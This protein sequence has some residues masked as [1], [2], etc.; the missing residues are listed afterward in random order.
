VV[1]GI[2]SREIEKRPPNDAHRNSRERSGGLMFKIRQVVLLV[3]FLA[4]GIFEIL[5]GSNDFTELEEK[6]HSLT[7]RVAG[8]LLTYALE[9]IDL[10]LLAQKDKALKVV[11]I[12]ERI[13][14]TSVGEIVIRRR[15]YRS[16][17]G[18]YNFL[19]DQAV[20]LEP[21][22]R[23]SKRMQQLALELAT[24]MP[25]RRAAKVLGY[26]V[27]SVSPMGV[28]NTVKAAG[29]EACAE[30]AKLKKDI[31]ERGKVPEGQRTVDKLFIEGDEVYIRRQRSKTKG[32]DMKLIVGYEGK[33]GTK[34]C[35]ENRYSVA[36]VTEGSGIW[37]EASC[38]FG[39]KWLLSEVEKV[40]IGGDGA[41]WIKKGTEYFPGASYHLDPFHLRKRLTEA[42][43]FNSKTYEAVCKGLAR[44]DRSA[45]TK[46]L[47]EGARSLRGAR[48]KKVK[49]LEL[50]LMDNWQGISNLP[51]EERLGAIEGQVRHT[52]AR[53]MKR[54]GARWT[55]EGADRMGRLLAAK[56]NNELTKYVNRSQ[57]TVGQL[58]ES[59]V[60]V[61]KQTVNSKED[62]GAWLRASMPALKGPFA[63]KPW[64][65]YVL[66]EIASIQWPA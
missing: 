45:V 47:E 33:S 6:V 66:R 64:I 11:G 12:R 15:M 29:E 18:E 23:I 3:L 7:Q 24:E 32:L 21:C 55:L 54:I 30:A 1:G 46:A 20:G 14:V 31:F 13:L 44:L 2:W 17:S 59:D 48:K 39:Q 43:S 60:P 58:L 51:E 50:Y 34:K 63:G 35:L 42:L 19:L 36:G 57:S 28:W 65:K 53:R 8:M 4:Q 26:L 56:A 62:L 37:E 38:A 25:F 49:D 40:H 9:E 22:R 5:K 52:I 10:R 61:E 16:E 41:A 27:P